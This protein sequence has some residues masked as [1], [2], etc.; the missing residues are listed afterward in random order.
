MET[1]TGAPVDPL[2][3]LQLRVARRADAL[4]SQLRHGQVS[5][6]LPCWLKAEEEVFAITTPPPSSLVHLD[7][8]RGK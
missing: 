3:L 7:H 1:P 2:V 5:L 8:S 6:N 4:A